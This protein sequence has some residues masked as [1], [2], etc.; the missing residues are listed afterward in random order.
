M[1]SNRLS[2]PINRCL[3]VLRT[4]KRNVTNAELIIRK[5]RSSE[6]EEYFISYENQDQHIL[7]GFIRLRLSPECRT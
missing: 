1:V 6:G 5:Y 2:V 7:H 4:E 3:H